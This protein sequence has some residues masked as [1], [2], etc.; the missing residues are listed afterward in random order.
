MGKPYRYLL[1]ISVV[2]TALLFWL[3][4]D[5]GPYTS[6]GQAL[7]EIVVFGGMYVLLIFLFLS[8]VYFIS[9]KIFG[10]KNLG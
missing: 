8:G 4:R 9:E 1:A 5:D 7:F 3:D 10:K 2:I 6:W